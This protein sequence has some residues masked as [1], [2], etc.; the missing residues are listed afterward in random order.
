M[1]FD[2]RDTIGFQAAQ[3]ARLIANRLRDALVPL[4][5]AG[6][7]YLVTAAVLGALVLV[8]GFSGLRAGG[9][10]WA[11]NVF[12]TSIIYLPVLFVVMV[13]DGRA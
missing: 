5:V 6:V 2:Q 13:L 9:T 7:P 10:K 12:L 8:Q 4:G 3:L 11:R 1:P